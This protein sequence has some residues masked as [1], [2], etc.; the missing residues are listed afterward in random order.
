MIHDDLLHLPLGKLRVF[1]SFN[2]HS[3]LE[4]LGVLVNSH[5]KRIWVV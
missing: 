1:L 2:L 4:L 3:I 5:E